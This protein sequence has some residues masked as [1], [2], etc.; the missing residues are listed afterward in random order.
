MKYLL[1]VALWFSI[2]GAV[3]QAAGRQVGEPR[4]FRDIREVL[5]R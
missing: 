3:W 4:G 1:A 5:A 2:L